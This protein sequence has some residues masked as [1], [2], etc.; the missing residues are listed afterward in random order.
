MRFKTGTTVFVIVTI[1]LSIATM[2]AAAD[3][4]W[5]TVEIF[6]QTQLEL[7]QFQLHPQ[8]EAAA[9]E[10][11]RLTLWLE[12]GKA[13]LNAQRLNDAEALAERLV[14][15]VGCVHAALDAAALAAEIARKKEA[16]VT[17]EQAVE[18]KKK[19]L[20]LLRRKPLPSAEGGTP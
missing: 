3:N 14:K 4:A 9:E 7:D 18:V 19:R 15:Q 10:I 20:D 5:R 8:K 6:R 12:E 11:S 2:A 13:H 17:A 16:I 1:F